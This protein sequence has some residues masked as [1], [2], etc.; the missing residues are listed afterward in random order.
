MEESPVKLKDFD[1][2]VAGRSLES[3]KIGPRI[4]YISTSYSVRGR[5]N[6]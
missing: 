1:G 5:R 6:S 2:P 4:N 3:V